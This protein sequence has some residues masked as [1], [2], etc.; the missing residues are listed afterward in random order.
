MTYNDI[1]N[2]ISLGGTD[3]VFTDLTSKM[4][5]ADTT[6]VNFHKMTD[7]RDAVFFALGL[8]DISKRVPCCI[9][10]DNEIGSVYTGLVEAAMRN[11]RVIILVIEQNREDVS[12]R[13]LDNYVIRIISDYELISVNDISLIERPVVIRC[14]GNNEKKELSI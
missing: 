1:I 8:N 14:Q 12:Y 7:A 5:N 11:K 13:F 4:I 3:I 6:G 2:E 9:V 10:M